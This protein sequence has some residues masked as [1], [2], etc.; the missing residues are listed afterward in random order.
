MKNKKGALRNIHRYLVK[1]RCKD[2]LFQA[3]K[4]FK[5]A[6]LLP[7]STDFDANKNIFDADKKLLI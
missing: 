1:G 6:I 3:Y 5:F 2:K 7:V 4:I